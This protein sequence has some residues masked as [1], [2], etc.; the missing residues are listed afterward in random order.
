MPW[1]TFALQ[2][3]FFFISLFHYKASVPGGRERQAGGLLGRVRCEALARDGRAQVLHGSGTKGGL[4][5]V[6]PPQAV[7]V[8]AEEHLIWAFGPARWR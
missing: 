8:E 1:L 4:L 6:D 3:D 7:P 5:W 2:T